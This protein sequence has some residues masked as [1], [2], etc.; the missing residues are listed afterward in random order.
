MLPGPVR[1][2]T[3][4]DPR[5][6]LRVPRPID[7]LPLQTAPSIAFTA[8]DDADFQ[9]EHLVATNVTGVSTFVTVNLVPAAGSAATA[10]IIV[11]QRVVPASSGVTIFNRE[12]MGFMQPGS[13]LRALCGVNDAVNLW[14]YGYDYQGVY[15]G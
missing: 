7:I 15:S 5:S 1:F 14:G 10:N 9:I 6:A 3:E 13:T 8:R 11:F 12:N 4:Q 2:Q